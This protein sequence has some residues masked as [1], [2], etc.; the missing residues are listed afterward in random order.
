MAVYIGIHEGGYPLPKAR[1][2]RRSRQSS[3]KIRLISKPNQVK[4]FGW[5]G[6]DP[7]RRME[8]RMAADSLKGNST[9]NTV[10]R[11]FRGSTPKPYTHGGTR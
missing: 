6:I 9:N 1:L 11:V 3:Q 7:D 2:A 10:T 4:A 8:D 5:R